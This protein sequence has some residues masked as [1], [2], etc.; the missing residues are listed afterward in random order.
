M[1]KPNLQ[2]TKL[3]KPIRMKLLAQTLVHGEVQNNNHA[4]L[5]LT[6]KIV[7]QTDALLILQLTF[8]RNKSN[9][10]ALLLMHKAALHTNVSL[11]LLPTFA[12]NCVDRSLMLKIAPQ[13]DALSLTVFVVKLVYP[14]QVIK[15]APLTNAYLIC[16]PT[17]AQINA[18]PSLILK[19]ALQTDAILIPQ[20][21][22]AQLSLA[23]LLLILKAAL[24]RDVIS[25]PQTTFVR[26]NALMMLMAIKI[27]IHHLAVPI[28]IFKA[29]AVTDV[30]LFSILTLAQRVVPPS[31]ILKVVHQ[32]DVLSFPQITFV[33]I[34]AAFLQMNKAAMK[35]IANLIQQPTFAKII[36]LHNH[37]NVNYPK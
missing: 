4:N 12:Q 9:L 27:V 28:L 36:L 19:V 21:T 23:A 22:I 25:I 24:L 1:N 14:L 16:Q 15:H 32:T 5:L 30:H 29:V 26:I 2:N 6:L 33:R 7:L 11:N 17:F 20:A 31:L 10:V 37:L 3:V 13:T 8:V 34:Y 35:I 18:A